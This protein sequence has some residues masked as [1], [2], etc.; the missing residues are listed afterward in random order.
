MHNFKN[1]DYRLLF[2]YS[3]EAMLIIDGNEFVD[4]NKATLDMLGYETREQ[5]LSSH[6]SKLSPEFQP[7]GRS[8]FEKSEAMIKIA[9]KHGSN[10]FEW[11]HKRANGEC[12]PV[13][14][15]LTAIPFK[16]RKLLHTVWRDITDRKQAERA[17]RES[18]ERFSKAFGASPTA[19]VI[20][21]V[22]G[23]RFINANDKWLALWGFSRD[24]VIGKTSPEI[25]V[26]ADISQRSE[27]IERLDRDGSVC[28]FEASFLTKSGEE[29]LALLAGEII[30][31]ASKNHVLL[32]F[33]DVTEKRR[34][35]RALKESE[36]RFDLALRSTDDG[37]WDWTAGSD[38]VF[39]SP[40]WKQMLGYSDDEVLSLDD[41][42]PNLIHPDDRGRV[43]REIRSFF[44]SSE[45][46]YQQ[47]FRL[48]HKDGH[49]LIIQSAAFAE[50]D[51]DGRITRFTGRHT[52]VTGMRETERQLLQ[53][54]KMEAVGQL[55]GGIAHDFNNLLQV[56]QG[57]LEM[58]KDFGEGGGDQVSEC[59]DR[60]LMA[61]QR[62]AKLTRQLLAFSRK[63]DLHPE[64]AAPDQ[65]IE[66]MLVILG[67]TLG[68]NIEI[69]TVF[70]EG[71][72]FVTIDRN[73]L[74]NAILNLAVNARA[75]M[76]NGGKLTIECGNTHVTDVFVT[77][78]GKLPAGRYVEISLTDT[79]FGM[80]P[81]V[82]AHVLEPFY[83]TK[84][85]G[86]GSGLGLSMVYGF[87][88][89]SGGHLHLESE[90][91]KG[92]T[93]RLLIPAGNKEAGRAS[94]EQEGVEIE[95]FTGSRTILVV[96][97]DPDV[98]A[99]AVMVLEAHGYTV[100]EAKDGVAA[101]EVLGQ[102]ENID[103]IFS[104]FGMPKG[105]NGLDFARAATRRHPGINVVLTSGYPEAELEKSGLLKSGFTLLRK[106]YSSEQLREALNSVFSE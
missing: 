87:I 50:R 80:R 106:P 104:D 55:T 27:L 22:D 75:A 63:Q 72:Q 45:H 17:L 20:V 7:D 82:L 100:L 44:K 18:E 81:D 93:V 42:F 102:H 39:L 3:T 41:P 43:L 103:V 9:F 28:E 61:G 16:D 85:I 35:E 30:E 1:A 51:D 26:W 99:S 76:P 60:A 2:D 34:S 79:G 40:R 98:R 67:R 15:L 8:S 11:I 32:V 31:I 105:M 78:D 21:S 59:I 84:D 92:T 4:C 73:G 47:E 46:R 94:Q 101:L 19:M 14:V 97:D 38:E 53:A 58:A 33:D 70:E 74:E 12:F 29:R 86:E 69:E 62:G 48:R 95:P 10:R 91:G 89:Q 90:V 52:D 56:I 54:Q 57:N 23:Y 24:E 5:L 36:R 6:P 65:L 13:E 37:L 64:T 66:G 68:D 25:G 77:E 96:E 71:I 88:K 83:T 49:Y